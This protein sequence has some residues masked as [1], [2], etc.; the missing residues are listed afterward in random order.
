M[1]V[2]SASLSKGLE[3]I[4]GASAATAPATAVFEGTE[5]ATGAATG[6]ALEEMPDIPIL[7]VSESNKPPTDG[8]ALTTTSGSATSAEIMSPIACATMNAL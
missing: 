3:P 2:R 8:E 5:D 4:F 7:P 6:F 1:K